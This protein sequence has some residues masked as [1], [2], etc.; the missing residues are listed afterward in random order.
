MN[1]ARADV[2]ALYPKL[3]S[4]IIETR[5]ERTRVKRVCEKSAKPKN[6]L[7]T[8]T[9]GCTCDVTSDTRKITDY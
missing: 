5:N 8:D 7:E 9:D 6:T 4:L 3:T 1:V 2:E